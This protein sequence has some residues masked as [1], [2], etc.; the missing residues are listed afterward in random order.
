MPLAL[1]GL[2]SFK[3]IKDIKRSLQEP[4]R[5]AVLERRGLFDFMSSWAVGSAVLLYFLFAGF[6]L[7]LQ[8]SP[9]PGFA[10]LVNLLVVTLLYALHGGIVYTWL[11]GKKSNPLETHAGRLHTI[12]LIVK[13]GVYSCIACV[14]FLSLIL[15]LQLLEL[16]RW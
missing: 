6:I 13:S 4:K 3:Y 7:D 1:V 5:K 14:L 15:T 12:G 8:A 11:Y 16:K 2:R 9:F 10:G